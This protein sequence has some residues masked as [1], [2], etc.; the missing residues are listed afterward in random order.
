MVARSEDKARTVTDR[1]SDASRRLDEAVRAQGRGAPALRDSSGNV[2]QMNADAPYPLLTPLGIDA[3]VAFT[4]DGTVKITSPD[5]AEDRDLTVRTIVASGGVHT[6]GEIRADEGIRTEA[7]LSCGGAFA[8]S[9][10]ATFVRVLADNVSITG[11]SIWSYARDGAVRWGA[12]GAFEVCSRDGT[13]FKGIRSSNFETDTPSWRRLKTGHRPL[14]E[15]LGHSAL[16]EVNG[17]D[18]SAWRYD[19]DTAPD[20]ADGVEHIG[21]HYD[22]L[23]PKLLNR[24]V[25]DDG[26][27]RE[28]LDLRQML[29]VALAAVQDLSREVVELRGRVD[30]LEGTSS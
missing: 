9:G 14:R 19:P 16:D 27:V 29:N 5:V 15:V 3:A 23:H 24:R 26:E 2:L 12:D 7:G 17:L 13:I 30:A 10:D 22:E 8:A 25:A 20:L 1:I 18:I 21:L 6:D 11:N 4:S 28:G